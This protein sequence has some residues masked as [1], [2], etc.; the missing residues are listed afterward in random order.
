[1][2]NKRYR[3]L[4]S[5]AHAS[6]TFPHVFT[7]KRKAEQWARNWKREMVAFEPTPSAR[8]DARYEYEWE[9]IEADP[10]PDT[11]GYVEGEQSLDYFNRYVAGDR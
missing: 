3:I 1:M 4:W 5:N 8:A 2:S 6:D 7:N 11:E 10:E 9:V